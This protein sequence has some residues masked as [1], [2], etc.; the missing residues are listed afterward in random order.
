M[1]TISSAPDLSAAVLPVRQWQFA[2][3]PPFLT[4]KQIEHVIDVAAARSSTA[5]GCR[6]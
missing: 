6:A 3:I 2:A 1:T 4:V 5:R